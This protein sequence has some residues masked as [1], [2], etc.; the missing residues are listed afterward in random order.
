MSLSR[1]SVPRGV[2]GVRLFLGLANQLSGFV[3]DF[4]H[5]TVKLLELTAKKNA[6]LWLEDHQREFEKFKELLTSEMVVTHF[7]PT[8]PVTI[9]TGASR[10]HGLGYAL[11]H[12]IKGRFK[13][14]SC[15]SKTPTQ[16]KYATIELECLA[17]YFA[18]N[19]CSF[20][21][22][23]GTNF[24]VATG[25]KSLE[26]IFA[27]DLYDILNPRL[28]RLCEKLVEYKFTVIW[29]PGKSH[30]IADA[31]SRAALF[32]PEE[33]EDMHID[34]ARV[35]IT[36]TPGMER[37]LN[38]ILDA[39]NSD[40]V[41]FKHDVLNGTELSPYSKQMKS[42]S[43]QLSVEDELVYIDTKRIVL[44]L[45]AVKEVL[46]LA[47]L[48]HAGIMKTY[49]LLCSLYFWP[50]MYNDVKQLILAC[51]P[52]TK[53][54][55]SLTKNPRSTAPPSAHFGPLMACVGVDLFDFGGK[56]HLVCVDRWSGYPLFS[57]LSSTSTASVID[58]LKTWFNVLGWPRVIRSDGEPQFR[59]EFCKFCKNFRIS[60]ELSSPYNPRANGLAKSGVNIVKNML[61]KCLGEGKD[62]QRVL[63]EWRNLSKQH[64]Y[65]PAQ[66]MPGRSRQ[67]LL[68]QLAGAFSPIDMLE[69]AAAMDE[70]FE[71]AAVHYNR[72]K[73]SL[74]ALRPGQFF[75][76]QCNK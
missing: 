58:T 53:N 18:I 16:Q 66:L 8:L 37:E 20:Y 64:G 63:Y 4:A 67:L 48:S 32:G 57:Q 39:I 38:S 69:A 1:F 27:K 41:K 23:G 72:D 11:G 22:K 35:C 25:H 45:K 51:G 12:Y 13:L 26:G 29:I 28:Q 2:T 75:V 70:K 9:L 65:S 47:H 54:A 3:P 73:V 49:E 34:S 42:V 59:G 14:V 55:V 31:L 68:P 33:T 6:F 62:M 30:H 46:R 43:C 7:D 56:S 19:K 40:Y 36:Q 52:L 76:I 44:P 74:P 61:H 17:V 50:G 15:G 21:L 24:T 5:M 71:A 10:L 60:H